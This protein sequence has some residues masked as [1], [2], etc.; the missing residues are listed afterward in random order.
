MMI[1]QKDTK[2]VTI[3]FPVEAKMINVEQA[4]RVKIP[5]HYTCRPFQLLSSVSDFSISRYLRYLEKTLP[6]LKSGR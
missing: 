5:P 3:Q 2:N 6:L 1:L 4:L